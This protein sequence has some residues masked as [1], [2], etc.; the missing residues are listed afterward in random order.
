MVSGIWTMMETVSGTP[1]LDKTYSF[2]STGW[3][4]VVGDWNGDG[5]TEVGV[6]RNG[7]W[8]LD[9][10]GNGVWNAGLDKTYSFGSTGWTPVVGDWNG[11]GKTETGVYRNGV[12]YLDYNGNGVWNAGLDKTYSFGSTGWT[13]VVGDWNGDG[14]TEVGV[15]RNGVFNLDYNG[16]GIRNDA[17]VDKVVSFGITGYTPVAGDWNGD[18][19]TTV[20]VTN[21]NSWY[22]DINGEAA[23]SSSS[24]S[25]TL[26]SPNGGE[27]WDRSISQTLTWS[28]TGNPGSTVKIVLLKGTTTIGTI[29]DNVP[30]GSSGKG[31]YVWPGWTGRVPGSDYKVSVQST[32]QP[33][34]KDMSNN[35][36]TVTAGSTIS[37]TYYSLN[38]R[39]ITQWRRE[40]GPQH[41]SNTHLELYGQSRVDRE[42]CAP[43]RN[44]Y[45]RDHCR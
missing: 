41:I 32:S 12:W 19:K 34:I 43:E 40:L 2:G 29:A 26:T 35:F 8:Y 23:P 39:Y 4:P 38:H 24:S 16:N 45:Y 13:L 15:Y 22:L 14:K 3:T 20:G 21:G 42:N 25:I 31:S 10:N 6:Y 11:D 27:N 30:I 5:K 44:Y 18:R 1:A 7:V 36:F 37:S 28:Y 33:T 17:N 9:Y